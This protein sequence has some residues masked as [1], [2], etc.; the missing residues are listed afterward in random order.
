MGPLANARKKYLKGDHHEWW[1]DLM[2][3]GTYDAFWKARTPLPHLK[4]VEPAVLTVGGWFDP[5]DL[6]GA[7]HTYK[8]IEEKSPKGENFLVMGPWDHGGWNGPDG[9]RIGRLNFNTGTKEA[10]Q[11]RIEFAFFEHY[12]KGGKDWDPSEA[13]VFET[14]ANRWRKFNTWPPKG[15]KARSVFLKSGGLAE[16]E[17]GLDAA[18]PEYDEYA[19]DPAKPV[20]YTNVISIECNNAFMVEDQRFAGRRPDVLVYATKELE[21]DITVAGPVEIDLWV[22]TSGTDSDWVVKLIDV[23]PNEIAD[24]DKDE[25]L[26]GYQMLVRGDVMRG[27]FR[28]GFETPEPFESN[29]PTRLR[30]NAPDVLHTFRKGHK[31]MVQVQS[32]WFPL[33]DRNPQKFV[34]VYKASE[35][36]FQKTIQRV[37]HAAGKASRLGLEVLDRR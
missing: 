13:F 30:W 12:L 37:Y 3:H 9:G 5:E 16:F 35:A 33:V 11:K 2:A 18:S 1:D 26:A 19:S 25:H 10:F 23:Y 24:G 22:S 4:D 29:E 15:T 21:N 34:D 8:T 20:P 27:R 17:S 28:N 14:G 36:D 31:L 7:L 32:S 6:W